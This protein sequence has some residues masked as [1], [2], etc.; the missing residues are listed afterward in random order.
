MIKLLRDRL[1]REWERERLRRE[2][3]KERKRETEEKES[4]EK[5]RERR[6]RE[7]GERDR[8]RRA[9]ER[10]GVKLFSEM[11]VTGNY[12][13]VVSDKVRDKQDRKIDRQPQL[14]SA[15]SGIPAQLLGKPGVI[16]S[17]P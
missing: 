16:I 15:I 10:L 2:R 14:I 3:P 11:T 5:E 4:E 13:L 1:K 7:R 17:G 12:Q 9:R 8:L 6:K